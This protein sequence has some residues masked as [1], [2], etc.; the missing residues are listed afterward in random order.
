MLL[1]A[2]HLASYK[3]IVV[4]PAKSKIST[5]STSC[6]ILNPIKLFNFLKFLLKFMTLPVQKGQTRQVQK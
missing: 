2:L 6:Q 5:I 1:I 4:Y 3:E